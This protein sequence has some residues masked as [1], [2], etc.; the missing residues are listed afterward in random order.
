MPSSSPCTTN[1]CSHQKD[2]AFPRRSL[3]RLPI[4]GS[5]LHWPRFCATRYHDTSSQIIIRT[6]TTTCMY[7]YSNSSAALQ[8][9]VETGCRAATPS[10][11]DGCQTACA[12]RLRIYAV[13]TG[14]SMPC[15]KAAMVKPPKPYPRHTL[16]PLTNLQSQSHSYR[17]HDWAR[18]WAFQRF[19]EN[20][21][22]VIL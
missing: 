19:S 16:Q 8:P 18:Y 4:C 15:T 11:H 13:A 5:N 12:V 7:T 10:P 2:S 3:S 20:D 9:V 21:Y 22:A 14:V 17:R 1:G 6:A